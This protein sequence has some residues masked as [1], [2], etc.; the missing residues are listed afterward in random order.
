MIIN[1]L[2]INGPVNI[3][4]LY[5]KKTKKTIYL[6]GDIHTNEEYQLKCNNYNSIDIDK[7]LYKFFVES[8]NYNTSWDIMYEYNLEYKNNINEIDN[9]YYSQKYN[10]L[11]GNLVL[12]Y[13]NLKKILIN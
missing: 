1:N 4:R 11:I 2:D 12:K 13:F 9:Y 10:V 8:N 3:I 6:F 5:N 7:L